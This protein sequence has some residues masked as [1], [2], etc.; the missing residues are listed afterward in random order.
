MGISMRLNFWGGMLP[1]SARDSVRCGAIIVLASSGI[2]LA[3]TAAAEA[4]DAATLQRLEAQIQRLEERHQ[5][6]IKALQAEIRQ[7]R[8][9]KPATVATTQAP[10]T[11]RAPSADQRGSS[12]PYG[13]PGPALPAK[14]LMTYDRGYHFGFSDATGDNTVELFGRL[15]LDTGGY[16]N[17]NPAPMTLDRKGLSDGIDLRRARIGV[18]GTFMTDWHYAFV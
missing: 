6:E 1:A 13:V 18:I 5:S 2:W 9:Q 11:T 17:Y 7:L 15:Q 14:V 12:A 10:A 3:G 16:T 4:E 8:R